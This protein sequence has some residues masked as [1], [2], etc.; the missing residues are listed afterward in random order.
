MKKNVAKR[1]LLVWI[2]ALLISLYSL[3]PLAWAFITSVKPENEIHTPVVKYWPSS[4]TFKNYASVI[5][6]TDFPRQFKNSAIVS[7]CTTLLCVFISITASY[8]FS[9]FRFKGENT[10]RKFLLSSQMFPKVLIIIPLFVIMRGLHLLNTKGSLIFAYT[11]FSL[12]YV[13]YML[14]GYFAGIPQDLD[15]AATIDGCSR[16][17]VLFKIVLPLAL[18]GIIATAIYAF[19]HAWDEL[20]FAVMFTSTAAQ[21]TLPVGLN[22]YIG[23]YGIEWGSLCAASIL[24]SLPVVLLFMFLQRYLIAGMTSGGVKE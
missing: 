11:S 16:T 8:A 9:R 17:G 15:E 18:P 5:K 21:R 24:T 2:P 6:T 14:I 20:M 3:I 7:G 22:M 13:I 4:P 19:I 23:E 10:L 1:L 12:P